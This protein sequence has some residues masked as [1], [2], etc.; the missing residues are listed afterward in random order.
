M[1]IVLT[2]LTAILV[3]ALPRPYNNNNNPSVQI[4]VTPDENIFF[5]G[6]GMGFLK[7][8]SQNKVQCVTY[9][10]EWRGSV[11]MGDF[12]LQ[13]CASTLKLSTNTETDAAE[14]AAITNL[15]ERQVFYYHADD[16]QIVLNAFGE[17]L[18][19]RDN[20]VVSLLECNAD[21]ADQRWFTDE[22]GRI[23]NQPDAKIQDNANN[24]Q[25]SNN[26]TGNGDTNNALLC[27]TATVDR[28]N[29]PE[30]RMLNC[31]NNDK[32][33]TQVFF[34]SDQFWDPPPPTLSVEPIQPN[35]VGALQLV[36]TEGEEGEGCMTYDK[37]NNQLVLDDC[38]LEDHQL[39]QFNDETLEIMV[40]TGDGCIERQSN[41]EDVGGI[42]TIQPC[43]PSTVIAEN[44]SITMP[45][46]INNE[47][48][49]INRSFTANT[50]TAPSGM[51]SSSPA[52]GTTAP[53][54]TEAT[55]VTSSSSTTRERQ[56][57]YFDREGRLYHYPKKRTNTPAASSLSP[58]TSFCL[59]VGYSSSSSSGGFRQRQLKRG[60]GGMSSGSGSSGGSRPS[61]GG[62]RPSSSGSRPSGGSSSS[63]S[64]SSGGS[65]ARSSLIS[66]GGTSSSTGTARLTDGYPS[67]FGP[68]SSIGSTA[69]TTGSGSSFSG[70][71]SDYGGTSS[72]SNIGGSSNTLGGNSHTG[73]AI[74]GQP[75]MS[76]NTG[77]FRPSHPTYA[78]R[79]PGTFYIARNPLY[80]RSRHSR[81][82]GTRPTRA[83]T[84]VWPIPLHMDA[85]RSQFGND[86]F[87][88]NQRFTFVPAN[89][90]RQ[91]VF[92]N[93]TG[94]IEFGSTGLCLSVT[95]QEP[96]YYSGDESLI[97]RAEKCTCGPNQE[98]EYDA[99][100]GFIEATGNWSGNCMRV[101][102]DDSVPILSNC[103]VNQEFLAW[104]QDFKGRLV[105]EKD[106]D[107]L[108]WNAPDYELTRSPCAEGEVQRTFWRA[109]GEYTEAPTSQPTT[110]PSPAPTNSTPSSNIFDRPMEDSSTSEAVTD[111]ETQEANALQTVE[112][113]PFG[114][115]HDIGRDK[116][117]TAADYDAAAVLIAQ[118]LD[119]Y[120]KTAYP[121]SGES[122]S[123]YA[124]GET[125]PGAT[126][127]SLV[128]GAFQDFE[129]TTMFLD[130]GEIPTPAELE[131]S[132]VVAFTQP[133]LQKALDFL[134]TLPDKNP[135]S[136]VKNIR[137][138]DSSM[139]L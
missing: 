20:D 106:K 89:S 12:L 46:T 104:Q 99:A 45:T 78:V 11:W 9:T 96:S 80:Y 86:P 23:R 125:T 98:F 137:A 109:E 93:G 67:S 41:D 113:I 76:T 70:S 6:M 91:G 71:N 61:S 28:Y 14:M 51:T 34:A 114:L 133:N 55:V 73:T 44:T 30:I 60:G 18:W 116:V 33:S 120:F 52:A 79:P 112:L 3:V 128:S 82:T 127:Y 130:K 74:A 75:T 124:R 87:Y 48:I 38:T 63:S 39:F 134:A 103:S 13:D 49:V 64:G 135:F 40:E 118:Y 110:Q 53:G 129:G 115:L 111:P 16:E 69:S 107:C 123:T 19:R 1:A 117:P 81:P 29:D 57:W 2:M 90:T 24:Q 8:E 4:D 65:G 139:R 85:C 95:E 27:L 58:S 17:C 7:V 121:E 5:G 100:N 56:Q 119:E 50:T 132:I 15:L 31:S 77:A 101:D 42:L 68:T 43:E 54:F 126:A 10:D 62:S 37:I 92:R 21:N 59:G 84:A 136:A 83:P 122:G 97:V 35:T 66:A 47:S 108:T 26:Q 138:T 105:N 131:A 25:L 88:D 32:E 102:S 22:Q 94:C 36:V 72:S